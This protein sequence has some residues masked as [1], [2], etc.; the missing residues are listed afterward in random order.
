MK[1]ID[2]KD[3]DKER[4][5]QRDGVNEMSKRKDMKIGFLSF[6]NVGI[7]IRTYLW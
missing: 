5:N 2:A 4:T 7:S 6:R 1:E 3:E